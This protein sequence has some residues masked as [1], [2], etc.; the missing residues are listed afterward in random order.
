MRVVGYI[1]VSTEEQEI[2]VD[3]Q[4]VAIE[5]FCKQKN[6]ELVEIFQDVGVSGAEPVLE[7]EGFK[8]AIEFC[9]SNN[10]NVIVVYSIDR[11][12]RSFYNIFE[13]LRRLEFELGI[14][15]V[16][17]KEEFLQQQDPLIRTLILSVLS[18]VAWY[19]RYLIR[20][21]TRRALQMRGIRHS[22]E[23]PEEKVR[24]ILDLYTKLGYSIRKIAKAV[25]VSER[26]V[27]KVLYQAGVLKLPEDVCPRCFS[28]L[29]MDD[30]YEGMMYCRNCGYLK[31]KV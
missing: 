19:E 12:G 23:L 29:V 27:R 7:R 17:V 16:S 3:V 10:I 21:R 14:K 15:V 2:S 13:T 25:G 9:K 6:W 5:Q 18:W 8:K 4:R 22:V 24:I 20:E 28:K 11:F 26:Q 31:P 30:Q 1:R